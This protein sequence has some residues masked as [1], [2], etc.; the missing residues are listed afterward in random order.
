M[1]FSAPEPD[2]RL[3]WYY[4]QLVKQLADLAPLPGIALLPVDEQT[5]KPRHPN[6]VSTINIG[7]YL[8]ERFEITEACLNH[9]S[10]WDLIVVPLYWLEYQL[11]VRGVSRVLTIPPGWDEAGQQSEGH[12]SVNSVFRIAVSGCFS[13]QNGA[14]LA[15]AAIR[16]F[17]QHHQDCELVCGWELSSRSLAELSV[18]KEIDVAG[19]H[20]WQSQMLLEQNGLDLA[21]VSFVK[22]SEIRPMTAD[23][24]LAAAR[25]P[26][27]LDP[28]LRRFVA[29]GQPVVATTDCRA[30]SG[31]DAWPISV[32]HGRLPMLAPAGLTVW[33]GPD[34]GQ[35]LQQIEAAFEGWRSSDCT[36]QRPQQ[37]PCLR[38]WKEAAGS[39]QGVAVEFLEQGRLES[40]AVTPCLWNKRGV[41]LAELHMFDAAHQQFQQSLALAP[42]NPET[43]NC[44]GNLLDKQGRYQEAVYCFDKAVL[45]NPE[46]AA[47]FFNKG[48]ALKNLEQ[49]VG[50]ADQYRKALA[51]DPQFADGWLNLGVACGLQDLLDEAESCFLKAIE[52]NPDHTDAMLLLGNQLMGQKRFE[53]AIGLFEKIAV[54]DRNH[55]LAYNS[56]GIA[57]LSVMEPEKAYQALSAALGIKPDLSSAICNIGTACRDMER[58]DESVDWFRLALSHEPNDADTHW[59][60]ALSLL[61]RGDYHEGWKEYEWRFRKSDPIKIPNHAIPLWDGSPLNGRTILLQAEQGY[62]DTIQ[63]MRYAQVVATLGGKVVV[64][65]QDNNIKPL[66]KQVQG[67]CDCV[68]WTDEP[69]AADLKFPLMSLPCLLKTE[70]ATIPLSGGYLTIKK[71]E[72]DRFRNL[73][74]SCLPTTALRI[75][76]AWDGRKTFRNDRRSCTLN[77]LAPIFSCPGIGF[78]SLQ[79]DAGSTSDLAMLEKYGI[80]NIAGHLETFADTAALIAC[81][82]LVVCVDTSVAHLAGALGVPTWVLLKVGPDWRWL[83]NRDESPWYDSVSLFRQVESGDWKPVIA[84]I[85]KKITELLDHLK[86][87]AKVT[88]AG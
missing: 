52:L 24:Y 35:I 17:M 7:V 69:V 8:P 19:I 5:F 12:N 68:S 53:E 30:P 61:H 39:L 26:A 80:I 22:S 40:Q 2:T 48:N 77:D 11:R 29:A 33:L 84:A 38:S 87:N 82:D 16:T 28:E 46:F 4:G 18:A 6:D 79:K 45:L 58:L 37:A 36:L 55:Y 41:A 1:I 43:Y 76:L 25:V 83:N 31:S 21:K 74:A 32:V 51:I 73:L 78:V 57:W 10:A 34:I 64:E 70:L 9:N 65:C 27:V 50:A 85:H 67:V 59:N 14:D 42:L 13:L 44:I 81:L 75:G 47:A 15:L 62:G 54:C 3:A 56:L 60:L 20:P 66:V 86:K 49:L 23:L 72:S 63:F 88:S 71:Q